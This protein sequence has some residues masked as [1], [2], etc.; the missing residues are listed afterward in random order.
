MT[1]QT[2]PAWNRSPPTR[3][4]EPHGQHTNN[5]ASVIEAL[6]KR[7][8]NRTDILAH[9]ADTCAGYYGDEH[10][11]PLADA[12]LAIEGVGRWVELGKRRRG[13]PPHKTP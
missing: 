4:E 3:G 2:K 6:R 9:V 7:V 10:P 1:C 5:P 11:R 8:G 12:L 13:M